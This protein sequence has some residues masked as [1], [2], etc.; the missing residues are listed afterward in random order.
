MRC[1]IGSCSQIHLFQ[2]RMEV[3][4]AEELEY[5]FDETTRSDEVISPGGIKKQ[6]MLKRMKEREEEKAT[7][8]FSSCVLPRNP[9]TKS[10]PYLSSFK[11]MLETACQARLRTKFSIFSREQRMLNWVD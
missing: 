9:K 3:L 8:K 5:E 10:T 11:T 1:S 2:T 4:F 7:S 6:L